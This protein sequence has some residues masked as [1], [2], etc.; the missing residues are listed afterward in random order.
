VIDRRS[1][2]GPVVGWKR[3][4]PS[5][6]EVVDS[7]WYGAADDFYAALGSALVRLAQPFPVMVPL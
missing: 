5:S 1:T 7:A 3:L 4:G 6:G 2:D